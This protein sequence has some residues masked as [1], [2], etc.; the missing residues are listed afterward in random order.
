M[1]EIAKKGRGHSTIKIGSRV[2]VPKEFFY[3]NTREEKYMG[4]VIKFAG[5]DNNFIK[6]QWDVDGSMSLCEFNEVSLEANIEPKAKFQM[7]ITLAAD[8]HISDEDAGNNDNVD[9]GEDWAKE[10]DVDLS[11]N[12]VPTKLPIRKRNA[13][14]TEGKNYFDII[15][16]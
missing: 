7:R 11:V 6:V 3:D 2:S 1:A 4:T 13:D 10:Q 15:W 5:V 16:N 12:N 9:H 14:D 8:S